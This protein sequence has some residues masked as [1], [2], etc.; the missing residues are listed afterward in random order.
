MPQGT[1][2]MTSYLWALETRW[3]HDLRRKM[4]LSKDVGACHLG[5]QWSRAWI[6]EGDTTLHGWLWTGALAYFSLGALLGPLSKN[7]KAPLR[8]RLNDA[9][10][11]W[12]VWATG[13][14]LHYCIL[15]AQH[16]RDAGGAGRSSGIMPLAH[17][18]WT[19]IVCQALRWLRV[20]V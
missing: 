15:R 18:G 8:M 12:L 19:S 1:S 11:L 2:A 16:P 6:H 7:R 13:K 9:K 17:I 20:C 5:A 4:K 14:R 3:Q 10:V